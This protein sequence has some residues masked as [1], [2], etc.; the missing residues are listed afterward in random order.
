MEKEGKEKM[1]RLLVTR[2]LVMEGSSD[3][4]LKCMSELEL[5]K[6]GDSTQINDNKSVKVTLTCQ[7][8]YEASNAWKRRRDSKIKHELKE[9]KNHV[10]CD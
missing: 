4:I 3:E 1:R 9:M 7:K 6:V 2:T 10:Q 8:V 5:Q